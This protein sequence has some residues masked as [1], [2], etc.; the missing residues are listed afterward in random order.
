MCVC[1]GGGSAEGEAGGLRNS[2]LG[3]LFELIRKHS[4]ECEN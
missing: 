1:V 2:Y 3:L 4:Q